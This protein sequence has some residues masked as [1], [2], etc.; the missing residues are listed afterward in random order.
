MKKNQYSA[1][2]KLMN[3]FDKELKQIL[4]KDLQAFS[5]GKGQ[6]LENNVGTKQEN[7]LVA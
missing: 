4:I 7:L 3:R 2:D 1:A 6:F 5:K